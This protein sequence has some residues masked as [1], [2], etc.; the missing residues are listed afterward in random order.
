M[1]EFSRETGCKLYESGEGICHQLMVDNQHVHP[2]EIFLGADSHTPTYGALNAFAVGVGSTDLAATM[3]T[4]KTWLKVPETIQ[5]TL[6][7]RLPLGVSAKDIILFIVGQ[8]RTD[9]ANYQA[10]EFTGE[11]VREMTLASRMVL[12]NMSAELGAK[13]GLVDPAGL[14]KLLPESDARAAVFPDA[15]AVYCQKFSFDVSDLAPQIALP[16]SLR[17]SNPCMRL[18]N[19]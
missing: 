16:H 3:L 18:A 10:V 2:G 9:G 7:G 15:D 5:I 19:S 1:R 8:L 6:N 14:D 17:I 4:G 11:A 13:T 12:A